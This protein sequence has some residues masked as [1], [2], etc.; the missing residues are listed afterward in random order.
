[1]TAGVAEQLRGAVD[2]TALHTQVWSRVT[3]QTGDPVADA[4]SLRALTVLQSAALCGGEPP[5]GVGWTSIHPLW[6]W[7]CVAEA[8]TADLGAEALAEAHGGWRSQ[9]EQGCVCG[10]AAGV[11]R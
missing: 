11:I 4:C 9:D 1:M 5:A 6:W 3:M 8:E 10:P 7:R 2:C